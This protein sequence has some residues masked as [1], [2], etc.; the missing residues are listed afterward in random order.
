MW[1]DRTSQTA[2]SGDEPAGASRELRGEFAEVPDQ[3]Q[4]EEKPSAGRDGQ[5]SGGR[6]AEETDQRRRSGH[7]K[8]EAE[9]DPAVARV[10]FLSRHR[11]YHPNHPRPASDRAQRV[12]MCRATLR[13]GINPV[14]RS[15]AARIRSYT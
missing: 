8:Q 9:L 13:G 6:I 3:K 1:G 4:P 5:L 2:G 7:E 12:F 11:L 10:A 14:D 15:G